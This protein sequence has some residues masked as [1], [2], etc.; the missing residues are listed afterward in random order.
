MRHQEKQKDRVGA[1]HQSRGLNI[2]STMGN[3]HAA[4]SMKQPLEG[5]VVGCGPWCHME[6]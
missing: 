5:Q 2:N 6:R 1:C 4:A 3:G